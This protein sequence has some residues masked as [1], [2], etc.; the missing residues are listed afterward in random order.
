MSESM[1][2]LMKSAEAE[3]L[4]IKGINIDDKEDDR[5]SQ[6]RN[7]DAVS[8]GAR[9]KRKMMPAKTIGKVRY[10][11]ARG[12]TVDSGAADNVMP[13][14]LLRGRARVR[15]SAA[16]KAGVNYV[17]ANDGRIPNEGEADMEFMSGEGHHHKWTFQIAEVNKVLASVSALVDSGHKVIFEKDEKTGADISFIV[18]KSTGM[19]TKMRRDRNVWVID[20]WVEEEENKNNDPS[21]G[22]PE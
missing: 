13:R 9:T 6:N 7:I 19:S 12:I 10:R 1:K 16:S 20:A 15:P 3:H 5:P 22:R 21:F 11:L 4:F 17:A 2:S 18:Q 8:T 14:R